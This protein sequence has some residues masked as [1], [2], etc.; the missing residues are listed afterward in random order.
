MKTIK[1]KLILSLSF[2]TLGQFACGGGVGTSVGNPTG[3]PISV[4]GNLQIATDAQI[5]KMMLNKEV[6]LATSAN[7]YSLQVMDVTEGSQQK[8]ELDSTGSFN[9]AAKSNHSYI[10]GILDSDSKVVGLLKTG[11]EGDNVITGLKSDRDVDLSN[12]LLNTDT[13]TASSSASIPNDSTYQAA[14][15]ENGNPLGAATLGSGTS[16]INTATAYDQDTD[17]DGMPNAIDVDDDNDGI[18]DEQD[19]DTDSSSGTGEQDFCE[20]NILLFVNNKKNLG[21]F[22][23]PAEDDNYIITQHVFPPTGKT[24]SSVSVTGPSYLSGLEVSD[25]SFYHTSISSGTVWGQTLTA[26]TSNS[27]DNHCI[28]VKSGTNNLQTDMAAGDEYFYSIAYDDGTSETCS[29]MINQVLDKTPENPTID[30]SALVAGTFKTLGASDTDFEI[31][32]DLPA[33][34][35]LGFTYRV[36]VFALQDNGGGSCGDGGNSNLPDLLDLDV[37]FT[38]DTRT[39]SSDSLTSVCATIDTTDPDWPTSTASAWQFDVTAQDAFGD[40][41]AAQGILLKLDSSTC[42][43]VGP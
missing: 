22:N 3:D 21:S 20:A 2:L 6:N 10:I 24:I 43:S 5:T 15:D 9:Y 23:S 37:T 27:Q 32:F 26:C 29:K 19:S 11:E 8:V 17:G 40:N 41:S 35:S 13:G 1:S 30:S 16:G 28:F 4:S 12:L 18:K 36:D 34:M 14:S 42:T 25:S 38:G 7:S 31:C 39:S 33:G